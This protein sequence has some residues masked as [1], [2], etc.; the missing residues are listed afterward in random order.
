MRVFKNTQN[1]LQEKTC[2]GHKRLGRRWKI[3]IGI[4]LVLF[5]LYWI[6]CYFLV[7][8]ALVPSFMEKTEVFETVTD[9]SIEAL[10]QTDD[11]QNNR[12]E[13]RPGGEAHR[14]HRGQLPIDRCSLLSQS[15]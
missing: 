13:N 15:F 1:T 3:L 12:A 14:N 11:I 7:S 9:V 10:V 5:I 6:I 8:L 2:E 4:L